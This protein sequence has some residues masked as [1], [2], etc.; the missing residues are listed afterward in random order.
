MDEEFLFFASLEL[1]G[2]EEQREEIV[3]RGGKSPKSSK[4]QLEPPLN[5]AEIK[6]RFRMKTGAELLAQ[7][8][9]R[10]GAQ[11]TFEDAIATVKEQNAQNTQKTKHKPQSK[12]EIKAKKIEEKPKSEPFTLDFSEIEKL[13]KESDFVRNALA[14]EEENFD[15]NTMNIENTEEDIKK[16]EFSDFSLS[17]VM[18]DNEGISSFEIPVNASKESSHLKADLLSDSL[19]ELWENSSDFH[20]EALAE[21]ARENWVEL[22]ELALSQF[23]TLEI[24]TDEINE[25]ALEFLGDILLEFQGGVPLFLEEYDTL[26]TALTQ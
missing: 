12:P 2:T 14:V 16:D 22:E 9:A 17:V 10:E 25:V 20:K 3:H 19:R 4:P 5:I 24:L 11:L 18:E 6:E 1:D 13:R 8:Q 7:M 23:S 21:I 26:K 15:L